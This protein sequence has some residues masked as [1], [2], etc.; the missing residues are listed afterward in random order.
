MRTG[1]SDVKNMTKGVKTSIIYKHFVPM[2]VLPLFF[3][4]LVS[5][6]PW[7]KSD[8]L[9]FSFFRFLAKYYLLKQIF[10]AMLLN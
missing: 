3:P 5:L 8:F 6:V 4:L 1:A 9:S 7:F 2:K 10:M